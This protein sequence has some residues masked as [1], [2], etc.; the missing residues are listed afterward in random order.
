MFCS[1]Q[2]RISTSS[3]KIRNEKIIDY[4]QTIYLQIIL[5]YDDYKWLEES[6]SLKSKSQFLVEKQIS[7]RNGREMSREEK[8]YVPVQ[9]WQ[10]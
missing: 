6:S 7:R 8:I 3:Y 2:V 4:K 5:S 10:P 9:L 1:I